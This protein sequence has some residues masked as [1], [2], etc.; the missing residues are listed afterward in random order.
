MVAYVA[1]TERIPAM[2]KIPPVATGKQG[3]GAERLVHVLG[4]SM[5]SLTTGLL[6]GNMTAMADRQ[7]S[8][9]T[10]LRRATYWARAA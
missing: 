1:Y 10:T 7:Q 9:H 3:V 6:S 5:E 8:T 2:I 4:T